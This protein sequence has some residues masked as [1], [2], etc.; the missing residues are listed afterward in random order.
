MLYNGS[1]QTDEYKTSHCYNISLDFTAAD[2]QS[3]ILVIKKDND[4][5]R[6]GGGLRVSPDE[7][8]LDCLGDDLIVKMFKDFLTELFI[9][10]NFDLYNEG[11]EVRQLGSTTNN[12]HEFKFTLRVSNTK[13]LVLSYIQ[14]TNRDNPVGVIE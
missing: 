9:V 5:V 10:S 2:K 14:K 7:K 11:A 3:F 12:D 6:R 8:A 13:P 1:Q 4:V